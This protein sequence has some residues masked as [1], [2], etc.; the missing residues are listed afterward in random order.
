MTGTENTP[1]NTTNASGDAEARAAFVEAERSRRSPQSTQ[2][3]ESTA[4]GPDAPLA[5]VDGSPAAVDASSIAR[6]TLRGAAA[7][8]AIDEAGASEVADRFGRRVGGFLASKLGGWLGVLATVCELVE[9]AL[10]A[11]LRHRA[12]RLPAAPKEGAA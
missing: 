3:A 11:H 6:T 9:W 10:S 5:A 12:A 8:F 1:E 7:F 4:A 2:A